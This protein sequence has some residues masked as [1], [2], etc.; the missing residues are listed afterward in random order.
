MTARLWAGALV[1]IAALWSSVAPAMTIRCVEPSRYRE[2][3]QI[4]DEDAGSL[5]RYFGVERTRLLSPDA[6]RAVVLSG[7]IEPD[8]ASR[9]VLEIG[10]NK[11]WLATLYLTLSGGDP[12]E[13]ARL[14]W[15]IRQF[16]LRT[17]AAR[18]DSFRYEPDFFASAPAPVGG[19]DDSAME[20]GLR[21]YFQRGDLTID[22]GRGADC[23][24]GCASVWTGGVARRTRYRLQGLAPSQP[25]TPWRYALATWIDGRAPSSFDPSSPPVSPTTAPNTPSVAETYYAEQCGLEASA[26]GSLNKRIGAMVRE[27]AAK[28][29]SVG[30]LQMGTLNPQFD[31]LRG[32]GARLQQCIAGALERKRLEAFA[33]L[34]PTG[35]NTAK[36]ADQAEAALADLRARA[37]KP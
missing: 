10:R 26:I 5:Y 9:L 29:F 19:V 12:M 18:A 25:P 37:P 30:A 36:I 16:W 20:K 27:A 31:S 2:L 28:N 21:A 7:K 23:V 3:M 11:G 14:A 22:F 8:D 24:E 6:C 15:T 17:Y 4:F 32:A 34:C 35:C 33:N 1:V 13:E